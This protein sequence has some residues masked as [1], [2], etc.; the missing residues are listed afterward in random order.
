MEPLGLG[1]GR[2]GKENGNYCNGLYMDYYQVHSFI[3][4]YLKVR[5]SVAA[6]QPLLCSQPKTGLLNMLQTA[7]L[8]MEI[9]AMPF[10]ADRLAD[11]AVHGL[12]DHLSLCAARD[13]A[14]RCASHACHQP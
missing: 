10:F 5:Q 8:K 6:E 13:F 7:K 1:F 14:P 12:E 9:G 11:V 4:S 3:P 2:N